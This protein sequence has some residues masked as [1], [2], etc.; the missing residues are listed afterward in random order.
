[1][2]KH[3]LIATIIFA[4]LFAE[5]ARRPVAQRPAANN[6]AALR[7]LRTA[8]DLLLAREQDR[9]VKMLET[10]IERYPGTTASLKAW[11]ALGKNYL[12]QHRE[13][14]AIN[15]FRHHR[16]LEKPDEPLVGDAREIFLESTYLTGVAYYQM[17]QYAKSFPILRKI[18]NHYPNSVWA[19]QSYYYIGLCHFRQSNWKKAINALNFVGTFID[20][21]SPSMQ[22]FEAGRR[23]HV[24]IKDTDL[25][26][27]HRLGKKVHVDVKT[28][29]GD[30]LRIPCRPLTSDADV[31]IGSSITEIGKAVPEDKVLQTLGGDTIEV[32]YSDDNT[33]TGDKD[34]PRV[35]KVKVVSTGQVF[36]T[37]GTY[38]GRAAAAFIGQPCF[39][40][41]KDADLDS[42]DKADTLIAKVYSRY[43][44]QKEEEES[45][46]RGIDI[47]ALDKE[48]VTWVIRDEETVKLVESGEGEWI[49]T[50]R[51]SGSI[52][53]ESTV[54]G[55]DA[56]RG[57]G[58][59]SCQIDDEVLIVYMDD[60]H[61]RGESP[62]EITARLKVAGEIENRPRS[63]QPFV[64]DPVLKARKQLV[65]GEAYLELGRIFQSMGLE[66]GA[67]AK[68]KQGLELINEIVGTTSNIP[69]SLRE[70]A[71]EVKWNLEITNNDFVAATGTC[72]AFNKLFPESPLVDQALIG[73]GKIK[74]NNKEYDAARGIFGR[75]LALTASQAKGEAQFMIARCIEQAALENPKKTQG[76]NEAAVAQFKL[77]AERYPESEFAGS[78][79][80]K[81]I[82]YYVTTKDFAQAD[83][84]L[85]QVFKDYPDAPFLDQMLLKWTIVSFRMGKLKKAYE[86]CSQLIFEF[87]SSSYAT[88]A[89]RV[90][91][92]IEKKLKA[93]TGG[94]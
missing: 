85:E 63:T 2:L 42:T 44:E 67:G 50:G 37:L 31:F 69:S 22:Y 6:Y 38:E 24:K 15:A 25:P 84:L 17:R 92:K 16:S 52:K 45:S 62:L 78:A 90:L 47:E 91:P 80:A 56:D 53:I 13:Q 1:M 64:P 11:L 12:D 27:L 49:R 66:E 93:S 82:D 72:E 3:T 32:T 94:E 21:N 29:S 26:T 39:I 34:V 51:F 41:A 35:G 19:N 10:V 75:I 30:V 4:S 43:R 48:Q 74:F 33:S 54:R 40:V 73:M 20:P 61:I 9:A 81:V 14:D 23:F 76:S 79:L 59:L 58:V 57:D 36:F 65:E 18:T 5:E 70:K 60:L 68:C 87:P 83:E 46:S 77:V 71:F 88:Q 89:K 7:L 55:R 28:S 8:E 86:K